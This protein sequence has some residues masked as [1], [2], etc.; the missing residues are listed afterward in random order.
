[1]MK[2]TGKK[3]IFIYIN[4]LLAVAILS[5]IAY[6]I[7]YHTIFNWLALGVCISLF[8]L[9]LK[10]IKK[11]YKSGTYE[12]PKNGYKDIIKKRINNLIYIAI[13]VVAGLFVD[14]Y[15]AIISSPR[16]RREIFTAL[17]TSY[18]VL[19]L[20]IFLLYAT[21][22]IFNVICD[23][24]E[25][26]KCE[27]YFLRQSLISSVYWILYLCICVLFGEEITQSHEG[28][29]NTEFLRGACAGTVSRSGEKVFVSL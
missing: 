10:K 17:G 14:L 23:K 27:K 12:V 29:E 25:F 4:S 7:E 28:T 3:R 11:D 16:K 5:A 15:S 19:L 13:Y 26:R 22:V 1:M 2:L 20:I 18:G 24:E 21:V 6:T 9:S 8:I